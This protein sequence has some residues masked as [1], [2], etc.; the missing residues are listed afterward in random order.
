MISRL[1]IPGMTTVHAIRAVETS[2]AMVPGITRFEVTRGTATITH[3][4]RA[5]ESALRDAVRVAGFE[6]A[7]LTEDAR[8][9]L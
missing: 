1:A 8:R 2:L 6:I 5:T 4:G 9:L 7:E 3:D